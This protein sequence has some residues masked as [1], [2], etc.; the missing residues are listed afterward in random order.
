MKAALLA[1]AGSR[2]G[3]ALAVGLLVHASWD[4]RA[5]ASRVLAESRDPGFLPP[6]MTALASETDTLARRALVD[7]VE[8]LSGR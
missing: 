2:G 5:A 6:L 8:L 7:A 3:G 1:G 4:V